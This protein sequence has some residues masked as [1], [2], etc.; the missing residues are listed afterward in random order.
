MN[1]FVSRVA[2]GREMEKCFQGDS[3]GFVYGS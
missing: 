3:K 1:K 2:V